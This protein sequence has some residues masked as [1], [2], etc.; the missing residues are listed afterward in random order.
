MFGINPY[1]FETLWPSLLG[2]LA[3][4]AGMIWEALTVRILIRQEQER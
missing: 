3:I 1:A 2:I 4:S